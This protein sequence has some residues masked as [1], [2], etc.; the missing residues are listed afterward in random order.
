MLQSLSAPPPE[1]A[2]PSAEEEEQPERYRAPRYTRQT[3]QSGLSEND[4]QTVGASSNVTNALRRTHDLI[5]T[6]LSR[7]EFAHQMLTE[8]SDALKQLNESYGSLDTMLSSSRDLLGTLLKSQKSDTWYLQTSF[9]MLLVTGA[10]LVF[11]RLLYGPAWWLV[12]LPIRLLFGLG[13][14]AGSAVMQA[15]TGPGDSGAVGGTNERVSVEGLSNEELPTAKVGQEAKPADGDPDSMIEKVGKIVEEA[16]EL[17]NIPEGEE[18]QPNT[19]KRTHEESRTA[20]EGE[21][22]RDEL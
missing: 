17:G 15:G 19:K 10:W 14:T 7:S 13:S 5:A 9:Y 22:P 18:Q 3:E 6:E 12:W 20:V 16:E 1:P 2:S 21:R 11:R 4:Q 8:S